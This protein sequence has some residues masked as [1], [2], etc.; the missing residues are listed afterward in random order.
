MKNKI[1]WN[2]KKKFSENLFFKILCTFDTCK[3]NKI[4]K[5]DENFNL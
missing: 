4:N 2:G 3:P 5:N 1:H